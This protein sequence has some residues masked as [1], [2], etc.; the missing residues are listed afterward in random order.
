M[1]AGRGFVSTAPFQQVGIRENERE[2]E[3]D[4]RLESVGVGRGA[5]PARL[6]QWN[7]Q[8]EVKTI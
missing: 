1:F 6:N 5:G 2:R 8:S 3:R 7:N 4:Q